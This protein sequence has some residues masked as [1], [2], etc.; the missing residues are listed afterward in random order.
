MMQ[1]LMTRILRLG[2]DQ[3]GL[4][5]RPTRF[6]QDVVNFVADRGIDVVFDVGGNIGQF[7]L[8][9]RAGG[10]RGK[11]VSFEPVSAVYRILAAT[12]AADSNW[13]A[14]NVALGAVTGRATI[15]ISDAT[16]FSSMLT[17]KPA[18]TNH[19]TTAAVMTTQMTDVQTLDTVVPKPMGNM[20]LKIDTQGYEK[21]VLEGGRR[22]LASMKGVLMELPVIHLYEQTWQF[23]EAVAYMADAG[24]IPAQIYPVTYHSADK[25]SLIEVD[26]L[27]RPR[28]EQMD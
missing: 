5:L 20:L 26:C 11:I 16:V 10:Y 4:E 1:K 7:G 23:H 17:A 19:E 18:A 22:A 14:N 21:M 8:S 3:F 9:L 6:N 12:A 28:N 13:E 24:F 27:F 2:L 25:V 15:N